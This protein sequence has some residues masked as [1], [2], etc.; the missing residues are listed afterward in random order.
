MFRA[1]LDGSNPMPIIHSSSV[2]SPVSLAIDNRGASS[3]LFVADSILERIKVFD[4]NGEGQE[5]FAETDGHIT[6]RVLFDC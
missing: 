2:S 5:K 4:S 6:G 1:V 3:K